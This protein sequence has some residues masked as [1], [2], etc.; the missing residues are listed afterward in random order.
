MRTTTASLF[1]LSAASASLAA[2]VPRWQHALSCHDL[3][4]A[5][6]AMLPDLEVYVAEDVPGESYIAFSAAFAS[7]SRRC[8]F[9][10]FRCNALIPC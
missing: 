1:A 7:P 8:S 5:A 2:V 3:W 4:D 9:D 10:R 6:P